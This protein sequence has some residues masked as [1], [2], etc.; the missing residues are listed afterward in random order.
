[1][2]KRKWKCTWKDTEGS[3]WHP[4]KIPVP[5][6]AGFTVPPLSCQVHRTDQGAGMGRWARDLKATRLPG[7]KFRDPK[8][9]PQY[10]EGT[11][12]KEG[13][14]SKCEGCARGEDR[15]WREKDD[16]EAPPRDSSKYQGR[17]EPTE[18]LKRK[19][20]CI[21]SLEDPWV[22]VLKEPHIRRRS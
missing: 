7:G 18:H 13:E 20:L 1:M 15:G 6:A 8:S 5:E 22:P 11:I 16:G 21:Y 12:T 9:D 17:E 19:N 3:R 10:E 2:Q 14:T 4:Q